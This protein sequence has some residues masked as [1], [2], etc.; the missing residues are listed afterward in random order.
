MNIGCLS[1]LRSASVSGGGAGASSNCNRVVLVMQQTDA[2]ASFAVRRGPVRDIVRDYAAGITALFESI[3]PVLP[4][5]G[6]PDGRQFD[7]TE[8][9]GPV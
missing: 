4:V 5:R 1:S 9:G 8:I 3:Y 6:S 2:P 7:R